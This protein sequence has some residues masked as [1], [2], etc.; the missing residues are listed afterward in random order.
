MSTPRIAEPSPTH[1]RRDA[2]RLL[3]AW[4]LILAVMIA[5]GMAL[6]GPLEGSVGVADNDAERW[7]AAHR[8]A[9]LTDA[10]YAASLLGETLTELILAP[11]LLLVIWLW[12]RNIRPV[13]FIAVACV[14]ELAAYLLTVNIVSRPRPPVVQL[15]QGLDPTHSYPSGHVAAAVATYGGMAVLVW[16]FGATRWRWLSAALLVPAPLVAL[17]RLYLGVH[18]PSDVAVSLLF[19][20]VWVAVTAVIVLSGLTRDDSRSRPG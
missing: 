9:A 15:D 3:L 6:T 8:S 2:V 10:A 11:V 1:L 5:V 12:Q 14:G 17:A 20:S 13:V 7:L 16:G 4:G 18:H 19:M